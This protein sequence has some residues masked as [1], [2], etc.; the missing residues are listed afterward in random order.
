MNIVVENWE[1]VKERWKEWWNGT[2]DKGPIISVTAPL[3]KLRE[4]PIETRKPRTLKDEW[5]NIEYRANL[6]H[7]RNMSTW[8][9]GDAIPSC[10]GSFINFGPGSIA[11]YLGS[12]PEFMPGTIWFHELE[13]NSLENIEKTL[14]YDPDNQLWNSTKKLTGAIADISH[15]DFLTTFADIGGV[16]DILSSLRGTQNLLMDLI[17]SPEMV[18][19]CENRIMELWFQYYK[20]LKEIMDASGQDGYTTWMSCWSD[21]TW[22]PLQCDFS[23]MISPDMFKEFAVP[24]L[25]QQSE[26]LDYSVY[27]WDGIGQIPHLD[28][29][30]AIDE[31]NAL[32]WTPGAGNPSAESGK[33]LPLHKKITEA[34]KGTVIYVNDPQEAFNLVRKVCPDR[35]VFLISAS[36]RKEGEDILKKFQNY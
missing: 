32:Q 34:G 16:M 15:G 20:E 28:H 1:I 8:F 18:K 17:G 11:G 6:M 14:H 24:R 12:K 7:N 3:E 9:G 35:T 23:A 30:L 22:Y 5:L 36:S 25:K 21:K 19:R 2:L 27:H 33:W 4:T 29:L 31:I 13:D 26:G 10:R